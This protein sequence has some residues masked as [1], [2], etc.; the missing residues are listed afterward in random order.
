M[1][2]RHGAFV[3]HVRQEVRGAR[4]ESVCGT[5]SYNGVRAEAFIR[6]R[7]ISGFPRSIGKRTILAYCYRRFIRV[8]RFN[9][10]TRTVILGTCRVRQ[11]LQALR[12]NITHTH[13]YDARNRVSIFSI[14]HNNK[15]TYI[16]RMY[17][18]TA[19]PS[20]RAVY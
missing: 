2:S 9:L 4:Y 6:V 17:E 1:R 10:E 19:T 5:L 18:Y 16:L 14:P 11:Q 8:C 12:H 7:L 3:Q 13:E 15:N 20:G